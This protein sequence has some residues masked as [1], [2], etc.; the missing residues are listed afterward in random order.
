MTSCGIFSDILDRKLGDFDPE[1]P[2]VSAC[3]WRRPSPGPTVLYFD[4]RFHGAAVPPRQTPGKV[5]PEP[6]VRPSVRPA[7][8]ARLR[9]ILTPSQRRALEDLASHGA[10]LAADFTDGELRSAFR[11]LARQYHPDRHPESG[12]VEQARLSRTFASLTDAYRQLITASTD[13]LSLAA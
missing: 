4:L 10:T 5:S 13:A 6:L 9:R 12:A 8:P 11:A 3:A 2:A 1:P 7:C